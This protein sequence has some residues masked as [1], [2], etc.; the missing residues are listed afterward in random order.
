MF[1]PRSPRG[2][3]MTLPVVAPPPFMTKEFTIAQ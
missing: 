3:D 1:C 2:A